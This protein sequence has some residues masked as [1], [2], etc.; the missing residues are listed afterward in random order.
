M[1]G[2]R[3]T[4]SAKRGTK[5]LAGLELV[6]N[7]DSFEFSFIEDAM[8]NDV[9]RRKKSRAAAGD[10]FACRKEKQTTTTF[11]QRPE[12]GIP[13]GSLISFVERL[14]VASTTFHEN[15]LEFNIV[16]ESCNVASTLID[17]Y[18]SLM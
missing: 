12:H 17:V 2:K 14:D 15:S 9:D 16:D 3:K 10:D 7:M 4:A 1:L 6:C 11:S 8:R 18:T 5:S 13:I